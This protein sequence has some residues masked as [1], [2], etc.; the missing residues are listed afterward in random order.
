MALRA[1]W[2]ILDEGGVGHPD[3]DT[4]PN[5]R[6][7]LGTWTAPLHFRFGSGTGILN[8]ER[9]PAEGEDIGRTR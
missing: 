1:C 8:A 2:S 6:R 9:S 7:F 5:E 4:A 3:S